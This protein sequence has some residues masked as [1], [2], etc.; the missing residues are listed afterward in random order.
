MIITRVIISSGYITYIF[1]LPPSLQQF[2]AKN[3][4]IL[5]IHHNSMIQVICYRK[6]KKQTMS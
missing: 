2:S 6:D 4:F 1:G 5:Y 3:L